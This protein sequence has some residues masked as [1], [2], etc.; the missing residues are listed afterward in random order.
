MQSI[1]VY[2]CLNRYIISDLSKLV[3]A[4]T[5]TDYTSG[6]TVYIPSRREVGYA[7]YDDDY[8]IYNTE[9]AAIDKLVNEINEDSKRYGETMDIKQ[10]I[11]SELTCEGSYELH[12]RYIYII[13]TDILN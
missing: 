9:D 3:I 13:T 1:L 6:S 12:E 5:Y 2:E 8:G 7:Y 10:H 4:Y 11:R